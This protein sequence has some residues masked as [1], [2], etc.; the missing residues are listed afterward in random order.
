MTAMAC[1]VCKCII[2][3]DIDR[4]KNVKRIQ[5]PTCGREF[6]NPYYEER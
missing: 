2:T 1:K 4:I 6:D 5:C 3:E